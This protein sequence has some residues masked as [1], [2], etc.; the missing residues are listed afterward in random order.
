M[1]DK[2]LKTIVI[3]IVTTASLVLPLRRRMKF[4]KVR[5]EQVYS[6]GLRAGDSESQ[7]RSCQ[8]CNPACS[9][10]V[11]EEC[12]YSVAESEHT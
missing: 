1:K 8:K 11:S 7:A 12:L 3:Q 10:I 5:G 2:K 6:A 4:S 9:A